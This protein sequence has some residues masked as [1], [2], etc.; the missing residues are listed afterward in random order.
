MRNIS[1]TLALGAVLISGISATFASDS[2]SINCPSQKLPAGN[3]TGHF[4]ELK[5]YDGWNM[6]KLLFVNDATKSDYC[7]SIDPNAPRMWARYAAVVNAYLLRQNVAIKTDYNQE[8][9]AFT[10]V[11]D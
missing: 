11:Q 5:F 7:I 3:Y 6:A 10:A 1:H 4:R 8:F 9:V 2:L